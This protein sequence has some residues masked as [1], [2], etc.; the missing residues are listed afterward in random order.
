MTLFQNPELLWGVLPWV[1]E[2]VA[3][4]LATMGNMLKVID[5]GCFDGM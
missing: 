1:Q 3:C 2:A 4:T 5:A